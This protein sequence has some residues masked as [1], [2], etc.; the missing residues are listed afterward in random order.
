MPDRTTVERIAK[1]IARAAMNDNQPESEAAIKSAFTR[2]HRDGVSFDDVLGLPDDLL[3]QKGLMDL[4]AYIVAQQSN[5]SESAKRDLYARY[6]RQVA[7]RYSGGQQEPPRREE[8]RAEPDNK[9]YERKNADTSKH[10]YG[11]TSKSFSFAAVFSS[12]STLGTLK[13]MLVAAASS[14]TRGGFMWHVL[15]SPGA[16]FRLFCAAALFSLGIGL[17]ILTIAALLHAMI[18]L[19]GPWLDMKF[20]TALAVIGSGLCVCKVIELYRRGWF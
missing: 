15:R 19:G 4:A 14:F 20:R 1:F 13:N 2:M 6:V 10:S 18:G 8:K 3:Y 7:N 11:D 16:A 9:A 17:L 12:N 5:L